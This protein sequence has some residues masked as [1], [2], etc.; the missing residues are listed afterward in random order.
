MPL[1][2]ATYYEKDPSNINLLSSITMYV[3]MPMSLAVTVIQKKIGFRWTMFMGIALTAVAGLFRMFST[4]HFLGVSPD[5]QYYL[6][7][8]AQIFAGLGNP[9]AV[10]LPTKLTQVCHICDLQN[11]WDKS[12]KDKVQLRARLFE[13]ELV[14]WRAAYPGHCHP[15]YVLS[16]RGASDSVH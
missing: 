11:F 8:V 5:C 10:S 6:S 12:K 14:R 16:P 3:G 7:L 1:Q 15:S 13:T 4:M 9:I 2:A